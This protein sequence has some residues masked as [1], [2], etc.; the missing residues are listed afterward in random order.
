MHQS[1]GYGSHEA[2]DG[3]D[4]GQKIQSYGKSQ[5]AFD[6]NHHALGEGQ[7]MRNLLH[8][9]VYQG[10]VCG[11]YGDAAADTAHGYPYVRFFQG[12][13]V[14]DAVA[15]HADGFLIFLG[16]VD[17]IHLILGQTVRADFPDTETPGNFP[18]GT[19]VI[20]GQQNG[21]DAETLGGGDHILAF[22]AQGIGQSQIAC[23]RP[24][25]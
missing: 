2:C 12:G 5:V 16:S 20:A 25:H 6:G 19:Q 23:V 22:F 1:S 24:C 7:K 18:G 11:V 9:V 21:S 13:G 8:L 4:N 15:D 3:Q 17:D 10:D 14:V